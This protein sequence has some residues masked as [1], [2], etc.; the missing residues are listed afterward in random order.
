M[1]FK[2]QKENSENRIFQNKHVHGCLQLAVTFGCFLLSILRIYTCRHKTSLVA[3][4]GECY[5][6][7]LHY[8]RYSDNVIRAQCYL[9]YLIQ[10]ENMF[11]ILYSNSRAILKNVFLLVFLRIDEGKN[12]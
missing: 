7:V 9:S 5:D 2:H 4:L 1:E 12:E 3:R 6:H 8:Y 10:P 11:C